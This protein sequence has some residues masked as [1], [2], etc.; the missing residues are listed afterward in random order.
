MPRRAEAVQEIQTPE[1]ESEKVTK[2]IRDFCFIPEGSHLGQPAMLLPEQEAQVRRIYDRGEDQTVAAPLPAYLALL[3][4][5][6]PMAKEDPPLEAVD[7]WTVWRC[8]SEPLRAVLRRDGE[9]IVCPELGTTYP[10]RA[11]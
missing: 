8:A 1:P 4:V 11:A 7:P 10:A 6:G 9:R 5:A 3:H 2:F